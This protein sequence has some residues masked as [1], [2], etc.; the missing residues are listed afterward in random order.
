M[1]FFM[2]VSY[3]TRY[4]QSM[5]GARRQ[6]RMAPP[7]GRQ[8]IPDCKIG[9]EYILNKNSKLKSGTGGVR[10]ARRGS[11]GALRAKRP[12]ERPE[13]ILHFDKIRKF[14]RYLVKKSGH[15]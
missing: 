7:A 10:R 15:F 11:V 4:P 13:F 12:A 6:Y 1:V 2:K 14:S 9:A 5:S 8:P 3:H